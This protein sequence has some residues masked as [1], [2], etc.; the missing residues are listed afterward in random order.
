MI[1]RLLSILLCLSGQGDDPFFEAE[2]LFSFT[3]DH[4]H[5]STLVE[6][7][8]GDLLAAWF[9]GS[10][11]RQADDVGIRGARRRKGDAAWSASF[12]MADAPGFPDINPVLFVDRDERLWLLWYTVMGNQWETSLPMYRLSDQYEGDGPPEWRWQE[13]LHF[14][15]GRRTERGIQP[16]DPFAVSI[17]NQLAR[18]EA[19]PEATGALAP[20]ELRAQ[21]G[22]YV[23]RIVSLARGENMMRRGRRTHADSTFIEQPMGYPHFRR[24]GWQTRNKPL[25]LESGRMIVPYYSDGFNFSLMAITDDGGA[26]W[27]F[28][29]PLVGVGIIQP[30][31]G[32]RSDGTLL[33]LMRDNGPPPKRLHSSTSKDEG[34][35]WKDVEDTLLPDPGSAAD[36]VVLKSGRSALV[37]NDT[38]SGRH[39][40]SVAL[41]ED[42]GRTWPWR[43]SVESDRPGGARSHY[44]AIIQS[45]DGLIHLLYSYHLDDARKTI[46]HARFN[47]DW[48][49]QQ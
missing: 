22:S 14:K 45:A 27:R 38:E 34:I 2:N 25:Q 11:E 21:W 37:S 1:P 47:E 8:S 24:L 33:A 39:R 19:R 41:I 15:P 4:V 23:R 5:G 7:P 32:Q 18:K 44:A 13:V 29:A 6:L 17:E 12:S 36:L 35:S 30:A 28:S 10:G 16:D 46:K 49:L 42:E 9:Q 40:L 20:Q 43:R 48:I 3:Q 26:S 31:L